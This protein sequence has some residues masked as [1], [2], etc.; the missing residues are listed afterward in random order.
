MTD[1]PSINYSAN[2]NK[3]KKAETEEIKAERPKLEPIVTEGTAR[4]K[5][6][7]LGKRFADVFTGDDAKS[8]VRVVTMDVIVPA[9]KN[10]VA[11]TATSFVERMLFGDVKGRTRMPGRGGP[12]IVNYSAMSKPTTSTVPREGNRRPSLSPQARATHNFDDIIIADRVEA[13]SVIDSLTAYLAEY[14]VVSVGEMYDLV[15]ISPSH[16]DLKFGW[17]DLAGSR[18]IPVRGGGYLLDLPKPIFLDQ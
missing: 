4:E 18:T 17:F 10:M 9:V 8:V 3:S 13:E 12:G 7:S 15:G 11:D 14:G 16:V 5:K 1:S 2:S 6:K